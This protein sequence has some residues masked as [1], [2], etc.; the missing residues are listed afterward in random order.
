MRLTERNPTTGEKMSRIVKVTISREML[1]LFL[2][3]KSKF[4]LS[5]CPSDAKILLM[6]ENLHRNLDVVIESERFLNVNE[7]DP[8]PY[9]DIRF[10]ERR[11]V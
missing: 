3:G 6:Q 9:Y 11:S 4:V 2:M 5:T 1:T 8:I 10:A 7:G